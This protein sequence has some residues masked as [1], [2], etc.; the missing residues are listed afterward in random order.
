[1]ATWYGITELGG[2]VPSVSNGTIFQITTYGALTSLYSFGSQGYNSDFIWPDGRFP[3]AGLVQGSDG[4]FYG[5]ATDSGTNGCGTVFQLTPGAMLTTLYSFT[6]PSDYPGGPDGYG[7]HAELVQGADGN[8]Y[9]TTA[10]GGNDGGGT[11]FKITP[12]GTF[13]PLTQF[14]GTNGW[15]PYAGLML[16]ND[17]N[18]YGTTSAGG[19]GEFSGLGAGTIFK[20]TTNGVQTVLHYFTGLED[21]AFPDGGLIQ[22]SDGNLYGTTAAGGN[23]GNSPSGS[24]TVF[25]ITTNGTL[26]TLYAFSGPDGQEPQ[27]AL[28]QGHVEVFMARPLTAGWTTTRSIQPAPAMARSFASSSRWLLKP[29][30][31]RTASRRSPGASCRAKSIKSSSTP[32]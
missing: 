10:A 31:K 30:R 20:L 23:T 6:S 17:G 29:S 32:I 14:N 7:P 3:D 26:T 8:F 22:G 28:V 9:G 19:P 16:G 25:E 15:S 21:G 18:F 13:T 5:T 2:G 27:G 1:M 24:G 4:N 12:T 11:V